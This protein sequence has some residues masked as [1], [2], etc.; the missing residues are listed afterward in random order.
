MSEITS[1]ARLSNEEIDQ[2]FAQLVQGVELPGIE[3][4]NLPQKYEP[5]SLNPTHREIIRLHVLGMTRKKISDDLKVS[6]PMVSYTI[7]STLGEQHIE[8]LQK[9]QDGETLDMQAEFRKDAPLAHAVLKSI[10]ADTEEHTGNRL[11]AAQDL[12]DRGG[13]KPSSNI[14]VSKVSCHLDGDAIS[15][16]RER[17]ESFNQAELEVVEVEAEEVNASS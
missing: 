9:I 8:A 16:I 14:N 17:A 11:R 1:T 4:A 15:K 7:N 13:Y 12:L 10:M 5:R 6:E 2:Q 3:E